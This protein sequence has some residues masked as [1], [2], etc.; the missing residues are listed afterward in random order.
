[1][2]FFKVNSETYCN[3]KRD[4]FV[5]YD[6]VIRYFTDSSLKVTTFAESTHYRNGLQDDIF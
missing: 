1:M 2:K 5:L 6:T 3:L 4:D